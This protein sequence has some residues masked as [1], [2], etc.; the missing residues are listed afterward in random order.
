[1]T[2]R[3]AA[4]LLALALAACSNSPTGASPTPAPPQT[5]TG[6]LGQAGY[7]IEVPPRWNGTL[8][9]YAHGYVVPGGSN[10]AIAA[11]GPDVSSWLLGHG[12]AIAGS[13]YSSTG[14]AV[15]D[16]LRDQLALLDYFGTRVGKPKRTIAWGHSLGG[17]ITAGLAQLH[18]ERLAAAVPMC[19]VVAGAVG[20][21]NQ[22]LDGAYAFKTLLAPTSGLQLVHI[23]DPVTNVQAANGLLAAAAANPAGQARLALAGAIGDL[24]GWFDPG[25]PEPARDDYA[26]RAA[27]QLLWNSRVDFLYAF[28]ARAELEKRAGGNPSWN[29]GVDYRQVL[30]VSGNR[31]QVTALYR[32][33]GLD[34]ERDLAALDAGALIRPD[35]QALAYL[36]RN[37]VFDGNLK[38][39]VLT[40][41][42]AGDG[43]VIPE[44]ESA[45]AATVRAA[46]QEAMLRQLFVHRAGHC[47]F[48]AAE[49]IAAAQAI[50]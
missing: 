20:T 13:S 16:A 25:S 22:A 32:T 50:L 21:W 24:P 42:T 23:G 44:Q 7:S 35:P 1:M 37:V 40:M 47:A 45:Y 46:G 26:G 19:G 5:L 48:T 31:D 8:F 10:A 28:G 15:E 17:I 11:P 9:L 18:P 34:L 3:A 6:T 36:Q 41:H 49:T 14:W 27:N 30:Q 4:L 29:A 43:L 38:I 2:R 12:Y 33:A 39:P